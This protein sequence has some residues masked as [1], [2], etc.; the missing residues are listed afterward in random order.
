MSY[1]DAAND[2]RLAAA[3]DEYEERMEALAAYNEALYH[4]MLQAAEAGH[5]N[6][7]DTLMRLRGMVRA[8]LN[9]GDK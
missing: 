2:D 6:G 7:Y 5:E 8:E 1:V 3:G 4:A 9:G